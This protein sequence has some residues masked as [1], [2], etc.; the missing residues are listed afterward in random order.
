[1]WQ[2]PLSQ[3]DFYGR[4]YLDI[5]KDIYI[6]TLKIFINKRVHA[7]HSFK[8]TGKAQLSFRLGWWFSKPH[9]V[10]TIQIN[11]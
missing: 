6:Y 1:M 4:M 11:S 10:V 7:K 8:L 2:I 5:S 3:S 9:I